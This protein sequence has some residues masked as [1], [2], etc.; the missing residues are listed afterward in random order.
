MKALLAGE[1]IKARDRMELTADA[2]QV[3]TGFAAVDFSSIRNA[4][5]AGFTVDRL[6]SI[7]NRLG[8]QVEIE[9]RVRPFEPVF[10][11]DGSA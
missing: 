6:I 7:L 3:R 4:D 10:G 5:L 11:T 9:I 8:A 1:I 2:A